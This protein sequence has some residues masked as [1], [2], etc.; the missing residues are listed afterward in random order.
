MDV[1]GK[2]LATSLQIK[3]RWRCWPALCV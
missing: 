3:L 1:N 2:V